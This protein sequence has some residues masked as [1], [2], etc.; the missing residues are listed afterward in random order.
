MTIDTAEWPLC[1]FILEQSTVSSFSSI[2]RL[3]SRHTIQPLIAEEFHSNVPSP[4]LYPASLWPPPFLNVCIHAG[5]KRALREGQY[6][7]LSMSQMNQMKAHLFN[8]TNT[9]LSTEFAEVESRRRA[10]LSYGSGK[11]S[12]HTVWWAIFICTLGQSLSQC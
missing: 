2:R 12:P 5:R 4:P 6:T 8:S 10:A 1:V 11:I 7:R 3:S 9:Q